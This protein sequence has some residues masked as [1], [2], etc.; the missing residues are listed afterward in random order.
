[1]T[2]SSVKNQFTVSSVDYQKDTGTRLNIKKRREQIRYRTLSNQDNINLEYAISNQVTPG[3]NLVISDR[4]TSLTQNRIPRSQDIFT[5]TTKLLSVAVEDFLLTDVFTEETSS[6]AATPLFYGHVFS[7]YNS[8]LENF[9]NL[10]LLSVSFADYEFQP[11]EFNAFVIDTTTGVLYNNIENYYNDENQT[12]EAYFVKYTVKEGSGATQ[13]VNV[14]YELISNSPVYSQATFDDLDDTLQLKTDGRKKYL[15]EA[16]PGGTG[17]LVT[18]PIPNLYA[19][20]ETPESRIKVLRPTAVNLNLP[21]YLRISNGEF[22]AS[23]PYSGNTNANFKYRIAEFNSQAFFPFPPYKPQIEQQAVRLYDNLVYVP[24][25]IAV[26]VG[27]QLHVDVV[28]KDSSNT[29][30]K[31]YTT[32]ENKLNTL[33]QGSNAY[34]AGILSID[35]L[36][37]IIEL[38]TKV[39]ETDKVIISYYAEDN[40]F[41]FTFIDF[42]PVTNLDILSQRIVIYINPE[43]TYTGSLENTVYYLVV[44]TLG[45]IAFS[46][47]AALG[48]GDSATSKLL[49]EDFYSTGLTK[50]D[51]YYDK[52]STAD[53]IRTQYGISTDQERSEF[54]FID[55]YTVES[56]LLNQ[57]G[58]VND[59]ET[60]ANFEA[61]SRFLVLADIYVG[62]NESPEG[63]DRFDVRVQGGGI[64]EDKKE[65]A[66][67]ENAEVSWYWDITGRRTYP[68]VGAF[69][70]EVP[71][72]LLTEHGGRFTKDQI[73]DVIGRHMK[74]GGYAIVKTYGIDP[75]II[76][77]E[78][79]VDSVTVRWPSYG[80]S[81]TYN[82]YYSTNIDTNFIVANDM[83]VND[84]VSG[85][86]FTI[87]NLSSTTKYY[88]KIGAF[89]SNYDE[90][91][92]PTIS[93]TTSTTL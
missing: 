20:R 93:A 40:E 53:G 55:K 25:R 78:V 67:A 44:D 27:L 34:T 57:P 24:K 90:S 39:L 87:E 36:N 86:Q 84:N 79:T 72:T 30:K 15:L 32:D 77:K 41:D 50:Y 29:V 82:V 73:S 83:L 26:D 13:S 11:I 42:N 7:Q 64:K 31:V 62:E 68:G 19:Y 21:W 66:L 10:T 2:I 69:L 46:S 38:D 61:N 65:L 71:Q 6:Q 33:Y 1:M 4:S 43:A 8:S 3:S 16:V 35:K 59:S 63:L 12:F 22:V 76:E 9:S 74:A 85:N 5:Q 47:Q 28:I 89:D 49:A 14:Y 56:I 81:T 48:L 23:L 52:A 37:G 80:A 17:Y 54:S 51:F 60:T 70:A 75:H 58:I 92:G 91:F 45:R 18:L 88:I